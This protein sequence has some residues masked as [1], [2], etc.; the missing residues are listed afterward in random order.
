MHAS[1]TLQ[2]TDSMSSGLFGSITLTSVVLQCSAVGDQ[3]AGEIGIHQR[4]KASLHELLR[5]FFETSGM[6]EKSGILKASW[7]Y[8]RNVSGVSDGIMDVF[9]I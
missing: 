8:S 2:P 4:A 9:G 1:R 3:C 7:A 5:L 6:V